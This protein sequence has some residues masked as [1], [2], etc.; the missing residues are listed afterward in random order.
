MAL[1][2][3][4]TYVGL[5]AFSQQQGP[6]N[7]WKE[8]VPLGPLGGQVNGVNQRFA[9]QQAATALPA[10][11]RG[12]TALYDTAFAAYETLRDDFDPTK[13]NAVVLITDGKNEKTGGL[14]LNGLLQ[15]LRAQADSSKPVQVIGIGLG[16]DADMNALQQI[17]AVTNGKAYQAID[18]ASFRGVL[19]DALSRRPCGNTTTGC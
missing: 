13:V 16:P 19:F 10:R 14:D 11:V 9:L 8:L 15:M 3:D 18:A 4:S 17:A 6:P 7:D 2:P 1:M 12:G 5:W